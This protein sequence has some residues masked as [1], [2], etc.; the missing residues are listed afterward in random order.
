[1]VFILEEI[2]CEYYDILD[3][4]YQFRESTT[5]KFT[6][7]SAVSSV[8]AFN[9]DEQIQRFENECI[10]SQCIESEEFATVEDVN[11]NQRDDLI[12]SNDTLCQLVDPL[13][14]P[15]QVAAEREDAIQ[16]V[17][18]ELLDERPLL[19]SE[20][21]AFGQKKASRAIDVEIVE[22]RHLFASEN[23]AF[24][25]KKANR[26]VDERPL[27]TQKRL[28]QE[29]TLSLNDPAPKRQK[30]S[31]SINPIAKKDSGSPVFEDIP[32]FEERS[33]KRSGKVNNALSAIENI[34][35]TK[36]QFEKDKFIYN[37]SMDEKKMDLEKQKLE[38]ERERLLQHE[39][40]DLE[41]IR[42]SERLKMYELELIHSKK[43]V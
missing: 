12:D 17:N 29:E 30:N 11:I 36:L 33:V 18:F 32:T 31:K 43:S 35:S 24:G 2:R 42:S 7:D 34:Q 22:E 6:Y 5:P 28:H 1:M 9:K 23:F 37:Q 25:Q 10:E 21:F 13:S 40:I 39:R 19:S 27:S 15:E 8:P 4:I 16:A 14:T 41:K 20:S 26:A 3:E 38:L